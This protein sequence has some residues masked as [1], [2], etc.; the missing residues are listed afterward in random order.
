MVLIHALKK[1]AYL[2]VLLFSQRGHGIDLTSHFDSQWAGPSRSSS[3]AS[4]NL[5]SLL[6]C[7]PESRSSVLSSK[8]DLNVTTNERQS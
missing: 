2:A 4:L 8:R 6:A 5:I 1:L 3:Q 7:Q